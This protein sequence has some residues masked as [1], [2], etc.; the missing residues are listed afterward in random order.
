LPSTTSIFRKNVFPQADIDRYIA[1]QTR[2]GRLNAGLVYYRALSGGKE[3]FSR[4]VEPPWPFPVLAI[5]GDHS[6]NGLTAKSFERV[7]PELRSV[8]AVDCGHFVQE[9]QPQ[10]LAKTLIEFLSRK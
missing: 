2:P 8:I 4:I 5:D 10:F 3:F 1:N 7:A 9:E 6:E